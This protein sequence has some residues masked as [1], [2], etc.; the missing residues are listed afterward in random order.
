[1]SLE[2]EKV[3]IFDVV[4]YMGVLYHMPDPFAAMKQVAVLT[5]EVAIIDTEADLAM[6]IL[7]LCEFFRNE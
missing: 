7:Q 4:L 6:R 3:G 2:P 5:R 1:M